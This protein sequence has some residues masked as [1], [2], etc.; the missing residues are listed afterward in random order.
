MKN[1]YPTIHAVSEM[2]GF[3]QKQKPNPQISTKQTVDFS[4]EK[5]MTPRIRLKQLAEFTRQLATL[6]EARLSLTRALEILT[7]QSTQPKLKKIL[8]EILTKIRGGESFSNCLKSQPKVFSEFFIS[9]VEVGE[10]G[11]ILEQTLSRLAGYLEKL[12]HLHR[13][14]LTALTYPLVIVLVA[15]GAVTFLLVAVVPTFA[16]MFEDFGGE[17]PGPTSFL[18]GLGTFVKSNF[19]FIAGLSSASALAI[20]RLTKTPRGSI[21]RDILLLKIPLIGSLLKKSFLAKFCRTLGTLLHSGVT[22]VD[23][24]QVAEK[25]S[26]NRILRN[27]IQKMKA[28]IIEGHSMLPA[29]ISIEPFTP[30][31]IQMIRVG[32]ETGELAEMLLKVA[33]FYEA[34]LDATIEAMTSI[35]EP[36]I[37]VFLGAI[38]GGTLVAMYLQLFNL[39]NVIQ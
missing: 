18:L 22:L 19:W 8:D 6:L 10:Q 32:E 30:L 23:A 34:E 28:R 33:G 15:I 5:Y 13:K 17:L 1:S 25:V 21:L 4:L 14:V 11:G 24:L 26:Q 29:N 3:L 31:T 35:I 20:V 27:A 36:V 38:L 7:E 2:H 9:L 12:A 39:V 16:D 37:I